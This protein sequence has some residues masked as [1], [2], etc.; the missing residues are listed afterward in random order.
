MDCRDQQFNRFFFMVQKSDVNFNENINNF[1]EN[2]EIEIFD[3][4]YEN[5]P[6]SDCHV[7][8]AEVSKRD[9]V[10][11]THRNDTADVSD[12]YA[13]TD[14]FERYGERMEF[15]S[16][17]LK[18]GQSK[19]G[20]LLKEANFCRVRYCPVC[21]WRKSLYWRAMM[22]QKY[23][24]MRLAYPTH[25]FLMLTLTVENP[26]ITDLRSTLQDM[27][28]AWK[29]LTMRKEF[30][31]VE[32]WIRTT[33]VTR[34][35]V[36]PNTHA[37]PHFHCLLMVKPSYF[38]KGY[39]VQMDWVR[40]WADCLRVDYLPNVDIRVVKKKGKKKGEPL[41]Y[42]DVKKGIVETLKYAVKP[43]DIK[44]DDTPESYEWFYELTRQTHKLRFVATGGALKNA[45]KE[46]DKI[47]DQDMITAGDNTDETDEKTSKKRLNFTY[48]S[49]KRKFIY[50]PE[51]N[52]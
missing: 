34:D 40:L 41:T 27:N 7:G 37:H 14:E 35:K 29:R 20:F 15:C 26:H 44:G 38:G 11:D 4:L 5:H 18:F 50:R 36:R 51:Y 6:P 2:I 28:K 47:T 3:H 30:G 43:A 24:D 16:G 25:H 48:Y 21:Q 32:G 49:S 39:V 52:E 42:E 23:D 46:D 8:L 10:W 9:S 31:V 19:S 13:L 12:I 45:L 33:E 22:Y 1:N 17:W